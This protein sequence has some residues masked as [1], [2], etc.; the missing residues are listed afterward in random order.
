MQRPRGMREKGA[1]GELQMIQPGWEFERGM[2][3]EVMGLGGGGWMWGRD[4][5][6]SLLLWK[7][8]GQTTWYF[9]SI[10]STEGPQGLPA[11]VG[12]K[13]FGSFEL[14]KER[15]H[16]SR[17]WGSFFKSL[18]FKRINCHLPTRSGCSL[19]WPQSSLPQTH[20]PAACYPDQPWE[21]AG[22]EGGSGGYICP[23]PH[24]YWAPDVPGSQKCLPVSGKLALGRAVTFS[25]SLVHTPHPQGA[26]PLSPGCGVQNYWP[27]ASHA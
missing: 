12:V 21:P 10:S 22:R 1:F 14:V 7:P 23:A 8:R 11:G 9:T 2:K 3:L 18:F 26:F 15:G 25:T 27:Q 20:Y 6:R 17:V 19:P 4:A 24:H 16:A 13:A 5:Q